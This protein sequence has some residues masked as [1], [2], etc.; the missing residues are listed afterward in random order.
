MHAGHELPLTLG[1]GGLEGLKAQGLLGLMR[2]MGLVV[3][4]VSAGLRVEA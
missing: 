4:I 3:L 2:L 1:W